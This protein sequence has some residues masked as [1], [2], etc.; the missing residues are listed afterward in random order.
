[1]PSQMDKFLNAKLITLQYLEIKRLDQFVLFA[2][3]YSDSCS[4]SFFAAMND[5][6]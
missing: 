6:L 2:Y 1:M 5:Q 4:I 3:F